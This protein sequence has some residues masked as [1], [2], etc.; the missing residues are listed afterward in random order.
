MNYYYQNGAVILEG[1]ISNPGKFNNL[2][3]EK[4]NLTLN[5]LLNVR[6]FLDHNRV[7]KEPLNNEITKST[8]TGAYSYRGKLIQNTTL[9]Q[10]LLEH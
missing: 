8:S 4:Y 3:N 5:D 6:S 1:D 2:L 10:N 9:E 7:F